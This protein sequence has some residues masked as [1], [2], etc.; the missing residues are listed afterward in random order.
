MLFHRTFDSRSAAIRFLCKSCSRMGLLYAMGLLFTSLGWDGTPRL[1]PEEKYDEFAKGESCDCRRTRC[2][3]R[4]RKAPEPPVQLIAFTGI[5]VSL[6][7][8][9]PLYVP[10]DRVMVVPSG[11]FEAV[12]CN[13]NC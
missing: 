8:P 11:T 13:G 3:V 7:P 1:T 12:I 4:E 9:V 2:S 10:Q 6:P 5:T